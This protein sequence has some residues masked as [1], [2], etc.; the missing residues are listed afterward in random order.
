MADFNDANVIVEPTGLRSDPLDVSGVID[1]GDMVYSCR[2][3]DVAVAMAYAGISEY[4][5]GGR[6]LAGAALLLRGFAQEFQLDP[7]ER[8]HLRILTAC[9]LVRRIVTGLVALMLRAECVRLFF[10]P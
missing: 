10:F 2:V 1:F 5:K 7:V 8:R 3:F 4:G 6:S 9:R